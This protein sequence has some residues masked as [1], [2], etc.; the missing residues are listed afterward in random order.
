MV[1]EVECEECDGLGYN[2][3]SRCE[4]RGNEECGECNGDGVDEDDDVCSTCD[5]DG[6]MALQNLG[7]H[8]CGDLQTVPLNDLTRHFGKFGTRLYQLSR[9]E[10]NR[11]VSPKRQRTTR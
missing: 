11:A 2:D 10:D 1:G 8:T 6:G 3:C 9:G 5:G 7:I 4:G